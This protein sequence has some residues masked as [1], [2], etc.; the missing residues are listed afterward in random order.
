MRQLKGQCTGF[1]ASLLARVTLGGVPRRERHDHTLVTETISTADL[2]GYKGVVTGH[3]GQP[4]TTLFGGRTPVARIDCDLS[5]FHEGDVLHIDPGSDTLS[6]VY[7]SRSRDN[8]LLVTERCN[9]RCLTCPQ[10]P[11]V[12][13]ESRT[14]FNRELI[15]LMAPGPESLAITGGEPTLL[16]DELLALLRDCQHWLP[17]TNLIILSNGRRFKE[18]SFVERIARLGHPRL[19]VAVALYGDVDSLHDEIVAVKGAFNDT[20]R[21]LYNLALYGFPVEIRV[22]VSSLNYRRLPKIVDFIYANM[23]FACHVALMGLETVGLAAE[24]LERIWVDP[25]DYQHELHLACR[26]LAR[27]MIPVSVYNVPLCIA[28]KDLWPVARQSISGWKNV[29]HAECDG[30]RVKTDCCG[31]FASADLRRSSHVATVPA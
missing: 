1:P 7:E 13:E 29:F 19:T 20:V 10:P 17:N 3:D 31:F 27:R 5:I 30:C 21:G 12:Q 14:A 22:V 2:K 11:K 18:R 16:G 15:R 6:L 4:R 8:A 26:H 24:N 23:P 28:P 9:C 25:Y